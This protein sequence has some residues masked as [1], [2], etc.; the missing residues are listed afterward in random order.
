MLTN[1]LFALMAGAAVMATPCKPSS[2]TSYPTATQS[3][4]T[5]TSTVVV[6]GDKFAIMSLRS[7]S[8]LHFGQV[9][10]A[11]GSIFIHLPS[12][13]A[14]CENVPEASYATFTLSDKGELYLYSTTET[15]QL[16]ADRSG[17]GQGKF[18]YTTG[19]NAQGPRNGER[20]TFEV[21]EFGGLTLN[22]AGFLA[23]PNSIDGAWS[24]W[25]DAG[26]AQP[27]G[28]SGCLGFSA[29]TV[30]LDGEPNDCVY[31]Q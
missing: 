17:M 3:S 7:A 10:A 29:R 18:G 26:V 8:P 22:G 31:T 12:Q 13:N 15:Q 16:Y 20:K 21:D 6:P 24:V 19:K 28:N 11:Q 5:P 23:C 14:T 1:A 30:K 9:S 25:A 4:T 27:A 2:A